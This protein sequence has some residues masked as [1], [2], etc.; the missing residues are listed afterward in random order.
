MS[1][2]VE[3]EAVVVVVVSVLGMAILDRRWDMDESSA[4]V[5][6]VAPDVLVTVDEPVG[7]LDR[8]RIEGGF[9]LV[10]AVDDW[11]D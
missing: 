4:V 9:E 5:V 3:E 8:F 11:V 7:P 1:A 10:D 6:V 2:L